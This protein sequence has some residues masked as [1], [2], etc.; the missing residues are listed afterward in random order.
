MLREIVDLWLEA[1]LQDAESHPRAAS[2]VARAAPAHPLTSHPL[3][4][5]R[6]GMARAGA[7]LLYSIVLGLCVFQAIG[8]RGKG[9]GSE[10]TGAAFLSLVCFAPAWAMG[11]LELTLLALAPSSL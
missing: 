1:A 10:G 8:L 4:Y 2:L 11:A 7:K 6:Y 5:L 3:F 9:D